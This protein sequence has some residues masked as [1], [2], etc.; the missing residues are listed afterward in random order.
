MKITFLA[1]LISVVI[2]AST[3]SSTLETLDVAGNVIQSDTQ[4]IAPGQ[5]VSYRVWL[6]TVKEDFRGVRLSAGTYPVD[7]CN[8]TLQR[9]GQNATSLLH[10]NLTLCD[11]RER[12][13]G[14]KSMTVGL[15]LGQVHDLRT[16]AW[17]VVDCQV[18]AIKLNKY[19]LDCHKDTQD[20][21]YQDQ[22]FR[23]FFE[24]HDYYDFRGSLRMW[25]LT[26]T[27]VACI[28][29]IAFDSTDS[30]NALVVTLLDLID[31]HTFFKIWH[32][33]GLEAGYTRETSNYHSLDKYKH[34][35]THAG[36]EAHGTATYQAVVDKEAKKMGWVAIF[37]AFYI[38]IPQIFIDFWVFIAADFNNLGIAASYTTFGAPFYLGAWT[39]NAAFGTNLLFWY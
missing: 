20:A 2:G 12:S 19:Q 25:I 13:V 9:A 39:S 1:C 26:L 38:Y 3:Y 7:N 32:Q 4:S 34:K 36:H 33:V 14:P 30:G 18:L 31:F 16:E 6:G 24:W 22:I 10:Q 21:T 37:Y 15:N 35:L 8:F 27:Y 28:G 23:S 17:F 11:W 29:I 5:P